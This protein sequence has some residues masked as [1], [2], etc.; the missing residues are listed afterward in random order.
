M[1]AAAAVLVLSLIASPA[2]AIVVRHDVDPRAYHA[3]QTDYPEVFGLLRTRRGFW[4]CPAT[5]VAPHW[6]ITAGHCSEAPRIAEAMQGGSGYAVEIAG[7]TNTIDR[8]IANPSGEDVALLHLSSAVVNVAP[9]GL[10][11]RSD[12]VGQIVEM[13]GWGDTGDGRTGPTAADGLFRRAANRVDQAEGAMLSWTFS[14]PGAPETDAV[15]L[16]GIS[17]PG[18]SGGP[19]FIRTNGGLLLAGI[20]SGQDAMGHARGTYGVRE[21]FVRVSAIDSWIEQVVSVPG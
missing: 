7:S 17:G 14:D 10:Y 9:V 5:L 8:V 12:E 6:A 15:S 16:E 21:Y 13:V 1:R 4:D 11:V 3:S 19:A 18:D 2:T 20:S